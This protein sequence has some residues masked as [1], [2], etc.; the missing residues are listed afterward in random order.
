MI[1]YY[2]QIFTAVAEPLREAVPGIYVTGTVSTS[3]TDKFPCVAVEEVNNEDTS[4]DNG[5]VAPE[6]RLQYKVTVLSNKIGG[7]V[8]E[9]R[10]ILAEVDTVFQSLNFRRISMATQD[11][12]YNNSAY[13]IEASYVARINQN[14]AISL[15]Q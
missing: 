11:G 9:A 6:A 12:M 5:S 13:K 10:R 4:I 3:G 14:G 2:P 7:R 1:D 15:S 8:T